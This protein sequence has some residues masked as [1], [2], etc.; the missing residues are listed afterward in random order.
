MVCLQNIF[1]ARYYTYGVTGCQ[2]KCLL[3]SPRPQCGSGYK[4]EVL[5]MTVS[6]VTT[7]PSGDTRSAPTH[8][9]SRDWR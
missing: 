1:G 4:G 2:Y 6:P 7:F 5:G 8:Y 3:P 9:K